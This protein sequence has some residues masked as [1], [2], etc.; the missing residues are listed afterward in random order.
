MAKE[1]GAVKYLECSSKTLYN[2]NSVF[3][4][5]IQAAL[6]YIKRQNGYGCCRII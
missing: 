4:G 6:G 1:I 5:A 3:E 2:L